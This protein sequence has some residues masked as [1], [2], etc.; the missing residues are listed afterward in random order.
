MATQHHKPGRRLAKS[1]VCQER[2]ITVH[3]THYEYRAKR[4]APRNP[5]SRPVPWVQLKGYW[6]EAAGFQINTPVRVRVMEGCLVLTALKR[7]EE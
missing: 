7:Q 3:Q 2:R 6:L 1:K 5:N 4:P